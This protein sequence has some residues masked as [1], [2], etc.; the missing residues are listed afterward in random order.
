VINSITL[1]CCTHAFNKVMWWRQKK[2]FMRTIM[3]IIECG[4]SGGLRENSMG[5]QNFVFVFSSREKLDFEAENAE[6]RILVLQK[7][8]EM[9]FRFHLVRGFCLQ[10]QEFEF[11]LKSAFYSAE[12]FMLRGL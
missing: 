2:Y 7:S 6:M 3:L 5:K 11:S 1:A 10:D 4:S 12:M 8:P 9:T